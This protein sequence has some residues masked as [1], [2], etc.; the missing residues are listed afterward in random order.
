MEAM[1]PKNVFQL[2]NDWVAKKAA[3]GKESTIITQALC[4]TGIQDHRDPSWIIL[5]KTAC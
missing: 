3:K 1:I 4:L 5:A 2:D